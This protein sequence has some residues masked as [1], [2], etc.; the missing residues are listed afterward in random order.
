M[1]GSSVVSLAQARQDAEAGEGYKVDPR[2]RLN[3]RG[4]PSARY[5]QTCP[6]TVKLSYGFYGRNGVHQ[7]DV[8]TGITAQSK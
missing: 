5:G 3:A 2:L 6:V 7:F 1:P 8:H 4:W